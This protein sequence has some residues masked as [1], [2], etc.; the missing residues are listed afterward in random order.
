MSRQ[1]C[2]SSPF[3]WSHR[4]VERSEGTGRS[5]VALLREK[6]GR[7]EIGIVQPVSAVGDQIGEKGEGAVGGGDRF[8]TCIVGADQDVELKRGTGVQRDRPHKYATIRVN[9]TRE[10]NRFLMI[11]P[12]RSFGT[13]VEYQRSPCN[14]SANGTLIRSDRFYCMKRSRQERG[15]AV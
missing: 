2:R 12:H 1:Q 15:G 5:R 10:R 13:S 3:H 7:K 11:S 6:G 14:E 9:S 4:K 8:G